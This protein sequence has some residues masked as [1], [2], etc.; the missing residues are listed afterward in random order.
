[1]I[2]MTTMGRREGLTKARLQDQDAGQK[3]GRWRHCYLSLSAGSRKKS[4]SCRQGHGRPSLSRILLWMI[5]KLFAEGISFPRP[6][7]RFPDRRQRRYPSRLRW[8]NGRDKRSQCIGQ[9]GPI[10]FRYVLEF[11]RMGVLIKLRQMC[12]GPTSK[13]SRILPS[14]WTMQSDTQASA[15]PR[16]H[17]PRSVSIHD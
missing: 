5:R 10:H 14:R 1:M 11:L 16:P 4:M 6:G 12:A 3:W 2:V 9:T 7:K 17:Q 8:G 13:G 15:T